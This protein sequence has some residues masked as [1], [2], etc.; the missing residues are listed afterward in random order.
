MICF[1]RFYLTGSG[2]RRFCAIT[3][4]MNLP[5]EIAWHLQSGPPEIVEGSFIDEALRSTQSD[6]LLKVKTKS[7]DPAFVY[8]LAEHK[9][10]PDIGLPLQLAGHMVEIWKRYAGGRAGK[11]RALPPIIPIVC[12]HGAAN[13]TVPDGIASIIAG[14]GS[15]AL[16]YLPGESYILRNLS[17]L[18]VDTLS[19]DPALKAGFIAMRRTSRGSSIAEKWLSKTERLNLQEKASSMSN[20]QKPQ[21]DSK[22]TNASIQNYQLLSPKK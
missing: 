22:W 4:P 15:E 14:Q 11:L 9:S 21:F 10:T 13:W 19:L 18:D 8:V 2:Q 16:S 1:A 20:I 3:C 12:Y 17:A 6:V 7:N 5:N